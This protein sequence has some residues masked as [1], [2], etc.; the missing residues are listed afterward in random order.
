MNDQ[1]KDQSSIG[2]NTNDATEHEYG[3][4]AHLLWDD[5]IKHVAANLK[6]CLET[7]QDQELP[8]KQSEIIRIHNTLQASTKTLSALLKLQKEAEK[9]RQRIGEKVQD[10]IVQDQK[11]EHKCDS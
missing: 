3:D 10:Q 8:K 4:K 7:L 9:V 2:D 1:S 11:H 6:V 5:T